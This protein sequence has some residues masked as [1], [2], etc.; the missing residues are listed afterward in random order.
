MTGVFWHGHPIPAQA[1]SVRRLLGL[2]DRGKRQR[3]RAADAALD[4]AGSTVIRVWDFE[5]AR[6]LA[7]VLARVL[8]AL[9]D[10]A[11][12]PAAWLRKLAR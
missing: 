9:C 4:A 8:A 3:D 12:G 1:A 6:D 5:V 7:R 2:Q 10:R 11:D